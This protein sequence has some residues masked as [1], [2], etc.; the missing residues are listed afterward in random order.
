MRR[1]AET[2]GRNSKCRC[3]IPPRVGSCPADRRRCAGDACAGTRAAGNF[4]PARQGRADSGFKPDESGAILVL[5]PADR[6]RSR[7][8]RGNA[9]PTEETRFFAEVS[10]LFLP[11]PEWS[12]AAIWWHPPG[13]RPGGAGDES[14]CRIHRERCG[15]WAGRLVALRSGEK[16]TAGERGTRADARVFIHH[17]DPARCGCAAD[18]SGARTAA[19]GGRGG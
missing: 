4:Q 14:A 1:P 11:G 16:R 3:R 15:R 19:R 9:T 5:G 13:A 6:R 10:N 12:T 2:G 18:G 8:A 17:R 7:P